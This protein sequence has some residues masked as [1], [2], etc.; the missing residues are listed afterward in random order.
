MVFDR[1][2]LL[3]QFVDKYAMRQYVSERV[4]KD[5]LPELYSVVGPDER[6][7]WDSLP[8]RFALKATHGCGATVLV[9]ERV[10]PDVRLPRRDPS[11]PW[12]ETVRIHPRQVVGTEA[13]DTLMRVWLSSNYWRHYGVTE[14]AYRD[15]P[16]RIVFEELLDPGDGSTPEDN[17]LWCVNGHVVFLTVDDRNGSKARSVHLPDWTH[18]VGAG[19]AL[20]DLA[21]RSAVDLPE[22][23]PNLG[24]VIAVAERLADGIDFVRVDLYNLGSRVVV[25]ELTVY[26]TGGTGRYS[27]ELFFDHAT[28]AWNPARVRRSS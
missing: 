27:P 17:K 22:R 25:G 18:I 6:V 13:A 3:T 21:V 28:E 16:P 11:R 8:S 5:R 4:G 19:V 20:Q 9:D 7:D 10:D 24:E 2:P 1:R 12:G 15:V 26:P 23:P 14:W